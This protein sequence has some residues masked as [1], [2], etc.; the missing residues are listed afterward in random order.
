[1]RWTNARRRRSLPKS[2]SRYQPTP[3]KIV[4][5]DNGRGLPSELISR[6]LNYSTRSS[7]REAYCS[8]TRGAQGN[9]LKTIVAMP[10]TIERQLLEEAIDEISPEIAE[11]AQTVELPSDLQSKI[12]QIVAKYPDMP[13]DDAVAM[14]VRD[15]R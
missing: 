4:V 9:A 3:G 11:R 13:W 10:F 1:M 5:T 6:I 14:V 2:R 15:A 12:E 7:S 8:P